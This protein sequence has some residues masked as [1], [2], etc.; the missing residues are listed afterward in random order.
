MQQTSAGIILFAHGSRIDSA[1]DQVR[2]TAREMAQQGGYALVEAAFL[3]LAQPDLP[4]AVDRLVERGADRVVV[5]PY[6][7]TL[8]THM[9][10]DLPVLLAE[11][12]CRH[13]GLVITSTT[14]LDGHP[15][16]IQILR[17]RA[18]AALV[19]VEEPA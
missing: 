5:V 6:F 17:D 8:G 13:P 19:P 14:P 3:E 11:A 18:D 12:S 15:A 1:N 10:R 2:E 4:S 7:L 9:Q 16:L